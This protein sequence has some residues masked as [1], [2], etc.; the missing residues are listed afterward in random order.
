[1]TCAKPLTGLRR[2]ALQSN[3]F[4]SGNAGGSELHPALARYRG[5]VWPAVI[6]LAAF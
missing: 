5:G 3:D 6:R 4:Q 2:V 1:M